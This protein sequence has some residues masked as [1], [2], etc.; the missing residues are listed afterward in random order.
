MI[1]LKDNIWI[2]GFDYE[3]RVYYDVIAVEGYNDNLI[4]CGKTS[5]IPEELAK[6]ILPLHPYAIK[7]YPCYFEYD[8]PELELDNSST[9][10]K[11]NPRKSRNDY[12]WKAKE[13]IQ[14]AS[15]QEYCIIYK[16]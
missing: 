11:N 13:S 4:Y 7:D 15:S 14:S 1:N 16:K 10:C 12:L 2:E 9:Q 3:S 6:S 8:N 5:E